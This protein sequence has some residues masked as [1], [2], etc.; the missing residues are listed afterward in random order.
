MA[1]IDG[2]ALNVAL[3]TLQEDLGATGAELLW[4]V[5]AYALPLAAL[6][7]VGGSLGDRYGRKLIFMIGIVIFAV[8]SL[9]CGV[10]PTIT[11]LI[12]ARMLQG[13]GG[14]LMVP[15][16]LSIISA[17]FPVTTRGRAIGTWSA[18]STLTTILGPVLGGWLAD[19]GFWR[20]IFFINL[21]LALITLAILWHHVPE[22]RDEDS[23]RQID[24]RG[25]VFATLGLAALSY[26]L[27][28]AGEGTVSLWATLFIAI[29]V[30]SLAA[31]VWTEANSP[32][33]MVNLD[34]FKSGTFAGTN[35]M[36]L[37]LYAALAGA[38]FF[39]PLNLVQVQGYRQSE[40]GF[41][42]LP[43]AVILTVMSRWAGG[44][45]DRYGPRL[46]LTIGPII[47]GCGFAL[48]ALIGQTDG[49]NSYWTSFFP[50]A[51]ML[52]VGMG[53]TVAPLTTAVMGSVSSRKAGVASGVNNAVARTAGVLAIAILGALALGIFKHSLEARTDKITLSDDAI[54]WLDG[55]AVKLAA[56]QVPPDLP[57]KTTAA[58]QGAI[59]WAF[60]DTFRVV[61]AI[62][63]S[64][65][66]LSAGLAALTIEKRMAAVE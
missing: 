6:I 31:F 22:S 20:G 33:P 60:I 56:A 25:A 62:A 43:F 63:A 34:L 28:Q 42:L 52:G 55:E 36:T 9:L 14:A 50:G 45:V 26:G 64:W 30:G 27:I 2:S 41:A 23:A 7:L 51:I 38:V 12:G 21:P 54:A 3:P 40:A 48:F 57:T 58:V 1:F 16:S 35:M 59:H 47:V 5:N 19:I 61:C 4:V 10:A 29:G 46:P 15:G 39:I 53:I 17:F 13:I 18:F 65:A 37:F 8:A 44:L 11:F 49:P 24:G 66:W 32:H